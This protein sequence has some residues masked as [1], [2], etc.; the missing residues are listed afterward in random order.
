VPKEGAQVVVNGEP[1][2]RV[3]SSRF[4]RRLGKAIGIAWVPADLSAEGTAIT[5][6]DPSGAS[7]PA[8]VTLRAFYDPD[9]ERLR[10]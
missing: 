7:I 2:G 9:Q 4:S 5:L 3:T 6:S 1:V 10:S 8:S